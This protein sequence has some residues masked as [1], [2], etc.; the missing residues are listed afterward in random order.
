M[1]YCESSPCPIWTLLHSF[2]EIN[3]RFVGNK[4]LWL[5]TLPFP[6]LPP[7]LPPFLIYFSSRLYNSRSIPPSLPPSLPPSPRPPSA[8]VSTGETLQVSQARGL[9]SATS[10]VLVSM[11]WP[12][13]TPS[14]PSTVIT[15]RT[16]RTLAA[17]PSLYQWTWTHH[18]KH[19]PTQQT[20]LNM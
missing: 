7:S 16:R 1:R 14:T 3:Q 5:I 12:A 8:T 15:Q 18:N 19:S 2:K 6:S 4:P 9:T 10:T 11:P 20:G 13:T 17:P